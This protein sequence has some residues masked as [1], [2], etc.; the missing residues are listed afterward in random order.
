MATMSYGLSAATPAGNWQQPISR[1][2]GTVV[3]ANLVPFLGG[4]TMT[5]PS[6]FDSNVPY[7]TM[8]VAK[9]FQGRSIYLENTLSA[10]ITESMNSWAVALLP[11]VENVGITYSWQRHHGNRTL[12]DQLPEGA[13][14]RFVTQSRD[15]FSRELHRI[16][17]GFEVAL[18]G[19]D[20]TEGQFAFGVNVATLVNAFKDYTETL[21]ITTL[22]SCKADQRMRVARQK[23]PVESI[24]ALFAEEKGG[25]DEL[26]KD[27]TGRGFFNML[28]RARQSARDVLFDSILLCEGAKG[29]IQT[30]TGN[31]DY[32]KHGPGARANVVLGSDAVGPSVAGL[33]VYVVREWMIDSSGEMVQPLHHETAI[34]G[35]TRMDDF[36]ADC[37][38]G[39]YRSVAR[40]IQIMNM[41]DRYG[42]WATLD[43]LYALKHCERFDMKTGE[44][45][46]YHRRLAEDPDSV[47]IDAGLPRPSGADDIDMFVYKR[48][49][50]ETGYRQTDYIGQMPEM[51]LSDRGARLVVDSMADAVARACDGLEEP[52]KAGGALMLDLFK[53]EWTDDDKK[54][55]AAIIDRSRASGA[56]RVNQYGAHSLA[57]L[58]SHDVLNAYAPGTF[59]P[60]GYGSVPGVF[61]I[62]DV[63]VNSRLGRAIGAERIATAAAFRAAVDRLEAAKAPLFPCLDEARVDAHLTSGLPNARAMHAKTAIVHAIFGHDPRPLTCEG[64]AAEDVD[65][66]EDDADDADADAEGESSSSS[67]SS[68]TTTSSPLVSGA[69][70][71]AELGALG[72]DVDADERAAIE[73]I[74]SRL[75]MSQVTPA[76]RDAFAS[77]ESVRAFRDAYSKSTFASAYQ[78]YLV[79]SAATV[80]EKEALV[81]KHFGLF[82]KHALKEHMQSSAA[83]LGVMHNL[84]SHVTTPLAKT[85]MSARDVE[86]SLAT[87]PARTF[88]A[89]P[90]RGQKRSRAPR[91]A[92]AAAATPAVATRLVSAMSQGK[93]VHSRVSRS[94]DDIAGLPINFPGQ[95]PDENEQQD[96]ILR[97][98]R[99]IAGEADDVAAIARRKEKLIAL[100]DSAAGKRRYE[101]IA[102]EPCYVKRSLAYSMLWS[103][104]NLKTFLA[105]FNADVRIPMAW[106]LERANRRYKGVDFPLLRAGVTTGITPWYNFNVTRALNATTKKMMVY[107]SV[108]LACIITEPTNVYVHSFGLITDYIG[109]ETTQAF[110]AASFSPQTSLT[111]AS[112]HVFAVP[113]L[114]LV[115]TEV[116]YVHD[117]TGAF[118]PDV[119][120][121]RLTQG[122]FTDATSRPHYATALYYS[123]VYDWSRFSSPSLTPDLDYDTFA[124]HTDNRVTFQEKQKVYDLEK[125][126]FGYKISEKGHFGD[127]GVY[128]GVGELRCSGKPLPYAP[129]AE[130]LIAL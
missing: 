75:G 27:A 115:G 41:K 109:G 123:L 33:Q 48:A 58:E 103:R 112:V 31:I 17:L 10:L 52:L 45:L 56:P 107:A 1:S 46:D 118:R 21:I 23:K 110:S 128:E 121:G 35:H 53:K 57:P 32:E 44:L 11:M 116:P 24:E 3:A 79:Q 68:T 65:E 114:S 19:L 124:A 117:I 97:G 87:W 90:A 12:P 84:V 74:R 73:S 130:H 76:V 99:R 93:F 86:T 55:A 8:S 64:D 82:A 5:A 28:E 25:F 34:G 105:W 91:Q 51:A 129:P 127:S 62:A 30:G 47:A 108:W 89:A 60:P 9:L 95:F 77:A 100:F 54:A 16:G 66:D 39:T 40:S 36:A 102:E 96:P 104:V 125:C 18:E 92:R 4:M 71:Q 80:A 83:L 6:G 50:P 98:I 122:A 119:V 126:A 69:P 70:L 20:T 42:T 26:R 13:G 111:T 113:Y 2:P 15:A 38:P 14:P 94:I 63:S 85:K 72:D 61:T 81:G 7:Q 67:S 101:R 106:L 78:R 88:S 37:K 120:A 49:S 43:P 22:K 59:A 29:F